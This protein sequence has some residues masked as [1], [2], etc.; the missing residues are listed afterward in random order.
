MAQKILTCSDICYAA[1]NAGHA[2]SQ[3]VLTDNYEV[4]SF[5]RIVDVSFA[6]GRVQL[7]MRTCVMPDPYMP[8]GAAVCDSLSVAEFHR[9]LC[10]YD[11]QCKPLYLCDSS[12][13]GYIV[14]EDA[15]SVQRGRFLV[16]ISVC[17]AREI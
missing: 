17:V 15:L 12:G 2:H 9:Y 11:Q 14:T 7:C 1:F 10:Q 6:Y 3:L 4:F 16:D 13:L 8:I 5:P